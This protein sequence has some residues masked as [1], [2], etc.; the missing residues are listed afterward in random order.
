MRVVLI[1]TR[2]KNKDNI[3]TAAWCFPL[4]FDPPLFG[5]SISSKRHTFSLLQE[6]KRFAINTTAPGMEDAA[7]LCGRNS[8]KDMDKFAKSGLTKEEARK[9]DCPLIK[10]SPLS[11]ECELVR[12]IDTGDHTLFVGKLVNTIKRKE[13]KGLYQTAEGEWVTV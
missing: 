11:I 7:M 13:A 12:T 8:G 2:S 4:S 1:T 5:V 3:M 9:I 6:A 10:E